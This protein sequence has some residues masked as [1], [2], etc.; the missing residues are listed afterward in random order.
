MSLRDIARDLR[1]ALPHWREWGADYRSLSRLR[2]RAPV[3][4]VRRIWRRRRHYYSPHPRTVI[5]LPGIYETAA[6]M[7]VLADALARRGHR[8]RRIRLARQVVPLPLLRARVERYLRTHD[9]HDV[10]LLAHSKGGLLGKHVM[11]GPEGHRID[12]LIA[13][14]APWHGSRYAALFWPGLGVRSLR[15]GTA[16]ITAAEAP[17]PSDAR[18]IS[19]QPRF[20]PH[21]PL[22]SHLPGAH[23]IDVNT[24]GHFAVLTDPTVVDL[25]VQLVEELT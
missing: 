15:P 16:L 18:I 6:D 12:R 24:A 3:E 19:V 25:V 5:L 20:D 7:R 23:N 10:V 2:L 21:V 1:A 13:L 11:M 9:L 22:G 14:A 4:L 17:S 8:I